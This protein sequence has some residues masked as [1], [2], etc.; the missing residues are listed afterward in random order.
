MKIDEI[1]EDALGKNDK[2]QEVASWLDTGY[3]PLNFAISAALDKGL[4]GGRIIEIF[5]P[6]SCGKTAIAT[7]AMISAQRA[8]GIAVF[9]DHENSFDV[10]LAED[11]GLDSSTSWGYKQPETFEAA[12]DMTVNLGR[13]LR[14]YDDKGK[15]IKGPEPLPM[16]KPIVVVYDSL[17]SM[18]PAS[19]MYDNK[20]DLKDSADFSMH[21][22]TAL[23]RATSAAFPTLAQMA[24]KF[25]MCL[26]FL[27]QVRTKPG[28]AY[29]DP[30]TTPGGQAPEFYASVRIGLSREMIKDKDKNVLG[31][32]I[33][34]NV[35]KNKVS[36][37]F[38][39]SSWNF[40]F[41]EDGSGYFDV[42]GSLVDLLA[43]KGILE[44]DGN[45]VIWTDGKKYMKPA[46]K[47]KI[48]AENLRPELMRLLAGV[49][50][51]EDTPA[52]VEEIESEDT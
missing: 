37:P 50:L 34:A 47:E 45:G 41:R 52:A 12:I 14:G 31:Q 10:G 16:D 27:N 49:T 36:A 17:A 18:V 26:I 2:Q 43:E 46:L 40:M 19:K 35:R 11:L 13:K 8:G 22:N 44:K 23:A 48:A 21:D 51:D 39:R 24:Y 6:P 9:M 42:D 28:V 3:P 1:L 32:I 38:K 7:M 15:K 5:G 20:G 25:N 33:N 29:G 4:P 30:T